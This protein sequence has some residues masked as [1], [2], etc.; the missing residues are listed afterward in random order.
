MVLPFSTCM[1]LSNLTFLKSQQWSNNINYL[2]GLWLNDISICNNLELF[3]VHNRNTNSESSH[4]PFYLQSTD[5]CALEAQI[6]FKVL[7]N[8]SH[9]TLEG[10][11]ANQFSGLL[12]TSDFTECHSTR[13]VM[14]R[15]LHP[16]SRGHTLAS[17]FCSQLLLG[18]LP[19]VDLRA[20]CFVRAMVQR[21]PYLP[22]FSFGWSS[23][24]DRR[25]WRW[26]AT[27]ARRRL[28]T[29]LKDGS[30]SLFFNKT[31]GVHDNM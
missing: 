27:A 29:Q 30:T 26:R 25:R 20:V 10:R 21:P 19:P 6:C 5:S 31:Y 7:S 3:L 13:P 12:I 2:T 14:M 9:Q 4:P 18:G 15:F 24:S 23:V 22:P 8:F 1:T 16:C 17:G 11:F 28:R